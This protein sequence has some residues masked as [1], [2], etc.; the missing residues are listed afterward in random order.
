METNVATSLKISSHPLLGI[1]NLYFH[2]PQDKR[3]DIKSY[4]IIASDINS[5]E[6]AIIIN[7]SL[8]EKIVKY[9]MLFIMRKGVTPM[10]E[11]PANRDGGCFSFKVLNKV[12]DTVWKE[13]FYAVCGETLFKNKAHNKNVTGITVSP[14]RN[15]CVIK[16]WMGG[17]SIQDPNTMIDITNLSKE[18]CLFKKHSSATSFKKN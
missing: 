1:W 5:A 4:E 15:F 2:L 6:R 13:L 7:E 11:D 10:W 3:W 18:G 16:V 17:C 9:C 12:V 8:P 14:K